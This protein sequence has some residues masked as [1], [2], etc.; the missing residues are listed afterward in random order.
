MLAVGLYSQDTLLIGVAVLFA[1]MAWLVG[2]EA[3]KQLNDPF[4]K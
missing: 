2:M 1:L 3:K 4:R